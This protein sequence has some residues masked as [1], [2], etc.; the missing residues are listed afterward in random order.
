MFP[1]RNVLSYD[2]LNKEIRHF[3][4]IVL[5][6]FKSS[7]YHQVVPHAHWR[8]AMNDELLTME[9]NNTWSIVA[10]PIGKHTVG[11]K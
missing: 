5:T 1:L 4:L 9:K 11:C 7:F 2:S 6:T 10:L 8:Q 3:S